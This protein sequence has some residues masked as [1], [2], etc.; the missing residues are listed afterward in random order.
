MMKFCAS[1]AGCYAPMAET[2]ETDD[3][4]DPIH[5]ISSLQHDHNLQT[6]LKS[7]VDINISW[8]KTQPAETCTRKPLAS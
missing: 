6:V 5:Q 1:G 2:K 4:S 7:C 3:T 8:L